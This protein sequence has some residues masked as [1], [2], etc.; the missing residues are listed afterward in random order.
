MKALNQ[1][2]NWHYSTKIV[3]HFAVCPQNNLNILYDILKHFSNLTIFNVAIVIEKS[4]G[5]F[6]AIVHFPFRDELVTVEKINKLEECFPD[7]TTNL[8][9][10]KLNI[11]G[12]S[13]FRILFRINQHEFKCFC[14]NLNATCHFLTSDGKYN[15]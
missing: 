8:H 6:Q 3:L 4:P 13:H 12:S 11:Y 1:I 2:R 5:K 7:K 15:D 10:Y 9:G 14:R